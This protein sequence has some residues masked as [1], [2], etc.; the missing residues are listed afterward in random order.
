MSDDAALAET[1]IQNSF[2]A[3]I[4][5]AQAA[6]DDE[7]AQ[8]L[9]LKSQDVA[10]TEDATDPGDAIESLPDI[11]PVPDGEWVFSRPEVVDYQ[12]RLMEAAFGDLATDLQSEWGADAGRNLEFALAASREFET[13]Y[14]D[15]LSVIESRGA[16][17]APLIIEI[18]AVLGR[19]WAESPGAPTPLRVFPVTGAVV[20]RH[21]S[22]IGH[23]F[24]D[25]TDLLIT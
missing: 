21:T 9:Y 4:E 11:G 15:I 14:P 13:H 10:E 1:V 24:V 22:D 6:G 20:V 19:Q 17:Y 7:R 12:F 5:E 3:D 25:A 16:G 8:A 23:N 2:E 18:L